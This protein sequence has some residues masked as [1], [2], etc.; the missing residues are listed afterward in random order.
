M[1]P[2]GTR[3]AW[4]QRNSGVWRSQATAFDCCFSFA[5]RE[6]SRIRR[7]PSRNQK[8]HIDILLYSLPLSSPPLSITPAWRRPPAPPRHLRRLDAS[9][10]LSPVRLGGGAGGGGRGGGG[11]GRG[12]RRGAPSARCCRGVVAESSPSPVVGGVVARSGALPRRRLRPPRRA[13]I[14]DLSAPPPSPTFQPSQIWECS[15]V[16]DKSIQACIWATMLIPSVHLPSWFS[17]TESQSCNLRI[18][19]AG[20]PLFSKRSACLLLV[21]N[22]RPHKTAHPNPHKAGE[23][24]PH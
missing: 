18:P 24:E 13:A 5:L 10:P 9:H 16:K 21:N 4:N 11:G 20:N 7:A 1:S 22:K 12:E 3:D 8:T 14:A 15:R 2:A 6:H 19:L 17:Q 23:E